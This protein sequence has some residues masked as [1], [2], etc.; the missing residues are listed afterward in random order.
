M[1]GAHQSAHQGAHQGAHQSAPQGAPHWTVQS[2]RHG[3]QIPLL[4]TGSHQG[5]QL[6]QPVSQ[7]SAQQDR[8]NASKALSLT[9]ARAQ[10]NTLIDSQPVSHQGAQQDA[11]QG[12]QQSAHQGAQQG[13]QP[14]SQ[15]GA[16][17]GAQQSAQFSEINGKGLGCFATI[18][19]EKGSLILEEKD[20]QIPVDVEAEE[21][22]S[23]K[24]I[25]TLG[26]SFIGMIKTDQ[27]EYLMLKQ[28]CNED[29]IDNCLDLKSKIRKIVPNSEQVF[30][31]IFQI[32]C[33]YIT[34][35]MNDGLRIKTSKFNHSC[36]PN[37]FIG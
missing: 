2:S 9:V 3:V 36:R 37:A 16:Q 31:R 26:R 10:Q 32:C 24:W 8:N 1:E 35:R 4:I 29:Y 12:A 22:G 25:Q 21:M 17:Q 19:I 27:D 30:S 14:V 7:Q 11:H 20:S 5:V 13:A 28:K 23:S 15:Q 33:I 34:Y 18:D 6:V